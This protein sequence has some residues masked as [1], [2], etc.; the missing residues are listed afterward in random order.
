M[1]KPMK[2]MLMT[3]T[4]C[5]RCRDLAERGLIRAE[6]VQRL[7]QGAAAP[8][9]LNRQKECLDCASAETLIRF[10][11]MGEKIHDEDHFIMARIAVGNDRQEQYRLPGA[12]LGLVA[13]GL[14]RPSAPGDLEEQVVWLKTQQWAQE[15]AQ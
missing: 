12:P 1:M 13:S 8:L 7:P 10:G 3:S 9:G 2:K 6:T 14:V 4:P 5:P 11:F 15:M